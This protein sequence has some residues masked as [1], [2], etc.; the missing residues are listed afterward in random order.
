MHRSRRHSACLLAHAVWALLA[1]AVPSARAQI[2]SD[3]GQV[4]KTYDL[5][6]FVAVAGKDSEKHVVDWILQETGYPAWHG[7]SPTS[8]SAADGKLSCYHT[9]DM[10]ARVSSI[11]SRFVKEAGNPHRFTIRVLGFT[12]PTWRSAARPALQPVAAATPGVQ[13]WILPREAAAPVIARATARPDCMEL[14]TGAVLAANGLPAT[15]K[16]GRT[17]EYVNDYALTPHAWPGWQPQKASCDEGFAIDVHPLVSEDGTAVDAVFR[18][19][20]DQIERMAAVALPSPGGGPAVA[21]E[22]PQ[23]AAV[24]IGE[25]FR[26]P[27]THALI[28]GLGLVPWPVPAQ[29][30]A[31]TVLLPKVERRDVVVVI[32]PRLASS[33]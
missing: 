25:R 32:E 27:A 18:C 19:R 14:P 31:T 1:L 20:V 8:L 11:V 13:A 3:I 29:N 23:M 21:S 16:G 28:I 5:A 26:W 7:T 6:A 30:G 10:Q 9:P 4:W 33:R 12:S 17:Q 24:R 15:L 22:V 2:P